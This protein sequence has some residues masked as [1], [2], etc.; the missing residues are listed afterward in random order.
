M[1]EHA[2]RFACLVTHYWAH[3][4]FVADW[5]VPWGASPGSGLLGG[6]A[7]LSGLPG[8][9]IHGRRD[10][11]GPA[12]TAWELHRAWPGSELIVVEEEGHGGPRMAEH[13][14]A[15]VSRLVDASRPGPQ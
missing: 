7:R 11:S 2:R 14:R 10:V 9:L 4:G 15:A 12:L 1:D 5:A 3:D 13:W 6:M 8:V